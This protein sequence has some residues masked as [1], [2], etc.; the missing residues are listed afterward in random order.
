MEKPTGVEKRCQ[1]KLRS[2]IG[3]GQASRLE[4]SGWTSLGAA[5]PQDS[6]EADEAADRLHSHRGAP[7]RN[8]CGHRA[9]DTTGGRTTTV[10]GLGEKRESSPEFRRGAFL[11]G[12]DTGD[13][14]PGSVIRWGTPKASPL[15]GWRNQTQTGQGTERK[16]DRTKPDKFLSSGFLSV[17]LDH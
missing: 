14:H 13:P 2:A 8:V 1:Q 6:G 12:L 7:C 10:R 5:S 9:Q 17:H 3:S 15:T 11:K 4:T 16:F